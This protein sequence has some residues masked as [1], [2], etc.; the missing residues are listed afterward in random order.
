MFV[1]WRWKF[2]GDYVQIGF[3][4]GLA[5]E[6]APEVPS[7]LAQ[8]RLCP[9]AVLVLRHHPSESKHGG[10]GA[11]MKLSLVP[12][13]NRIEQCSLEEVKS[14]PFLRVTSLLKRM[15]NQGNEMFTP[16]QALT[17]IKWTLVWGKAG[18]LSYYLMI[19]THTMRWKSHYAICML[20]RRMRWI[21]NFQMQ[22]ISLQVSK[23]A[24]PSFGATI[25]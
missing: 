24:H 8:I 21:L 13:Q 18:K 7:A 25:C 11:S 20:G 10:I 9:Q 5:A 6:T 1:L 12:M 23:C 22:Q 15:T 17:L 2:A 16:L 14:H 4:I 3:R 19:R